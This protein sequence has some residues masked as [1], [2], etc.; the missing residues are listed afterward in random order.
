MR[1]RRTFHYFAVGAVAILA[2][3]VIADSSKT[4]SGT[5]LM[6]SVQGACSLSDGSSGLASAARQV[7]A[8]DERLSPDS[9]II[10]VA[11][12]S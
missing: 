5:R 7:K 2:V 12:G 3:A 4:A 6:H 11:H 1:Y 10:A 9:V 8:N